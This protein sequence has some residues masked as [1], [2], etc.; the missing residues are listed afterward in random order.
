LLSLSGF[1]CLLSHSLLCM[2][3]CEGHYEAR[4]N[5]SHHTNKN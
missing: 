2:G 3:V 1:N 4:S 5:I